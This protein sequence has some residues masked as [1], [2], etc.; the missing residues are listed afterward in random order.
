MGL[1]FRS[2]LDNARYPDG[3]LGSGG[4]TGGE[5]WCNRKGACGSERLL[6]IFKPFSD[7]VVISF[8][9]DLKIPFS[10]SEP[11]FLLRRQ[12]PSIL[13]DGSN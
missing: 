13:L 10:D 12:D 7:V 2:K 5:L 8:E 6:E 1:S 4:W 9:L 3:L 11:Q